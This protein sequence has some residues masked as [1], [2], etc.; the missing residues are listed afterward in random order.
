VNQLG[1]YYRANPALDPVVPLAEED[2]DGIASLGFDTVRLIVHWSL[3]EPERGAFDAAYLARIRQAVEWAA[4]RDVYVV[5]DMHQDAWGKHVDTPPGEQC[6]PGF[7]R[8]V[9]WDGAPRW[10]TF[11]DGLPTCR[12]G[13]VREI[14][15]AVAQAWQ[16]FWADREGIQGRLVATWARLARELAAEPAVA[17]YDLLNEP[18]PGYTPAATAP[19]Q[20]AAFYTR[21]I[22]AIRAAE[23]DAPGGF[24]HVVFFEPLV[25]WSLTT[26]DAVPPPS[27]TDDPSV[28][29]APH[30]YAGSL[31][32]DAAAGAPFLTPRDG[33]DFAARTAAAYGT[34]YWSGEWGWF[35]RAEDDRDDIA[36]YARE[37]DARLVGGAWWQWRQACGDPHNIAEPGGGPGP[38]TGNLNRYAC[39]DE[40]PLPMPETT[41][42]ILARGYARAA[43][44]RLTALESDPEGG[45]L[46]VAGR[47]GDAA[48][49]CELVL[50][51]P[52]DRGA[53]AFARRN[54][55]A[56][57]LRS[58]AGGWIA[59]ACA[60]GD[61]E[62]RRT[63]TVAPPPPPAPAPGGG[64]RGQG[65][66]PPSPP[67]AHRRA[68]LPRRA[69]VGHRS[70]GRVRLGDTR[71]RTLTRA[72]V[73]PESTTAYAYRWC[74]K[75][76]TGRVVAVFGGR[77]S[78]SRMRLVA[79]TATGHRKR[80]AGPGAGLRA[81]L[82]RF[83][84]ATRLTG[85]AYRSGPGSRHLF[86]VRGG[87]VRY[88][89]IAD[90][91]LI[92]DPRALRRALRRAGV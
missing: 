36:A 20:L 90:P 80:G 21:A 48:G 30:V 55:S 33:H 45:A 49:G 84:R 23:R 3:L 6:A 81:L 79:T 73:A 76:S 14:A 64:S 71:G 32:G 85:G 12:L 59:T 29:F 65:A 1:D 47:D 72:P 78:G 2:L 77:S 22:D 87:R 10:A 26:V 25:V 66:P 7:T 74:V 44:G 86:G 41:R 82:R 37:E 27:F 9:G 57:S 75:G 13:G 50:W 54:A 38:E 51:V 39:P 58:F 28:V 70:V 56:V 83:P 69:T 88:A 53:P 16:S 61:Y 67:A 89:A 35:G 42:R 62:L 11:T 19:A 68:C 92:R 46:R 43:P 8:N 31:S 34:S 4:E 52:G 60:S 91:G 63:G 15:F 18:H 17:G 24:H 40:R 5:V